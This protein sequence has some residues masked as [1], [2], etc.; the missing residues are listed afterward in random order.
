MALKQPRTWRLASVA[1][2]S[3]ILTSG[4]VFAEETAPTPS[5]EQRALTMDDAIQLALTN[6]VDILISK[7]TPRV[8]KFGLDALYSTYDPV[9]GM[10]VI[11]RYQNIPGQIDP[12]TGRLASFSE[13]NDEFTP[14]LT[15]ALPVGTTFTINGPQTHSQGPGISADGSY[16]GDV[17]ITVTQPLLKNFWI[18][19]PRWNIALA[20]GTLR[21]DQ[22]ALRQQ[23]MTVI[24]NVKSAYYNL[25]YDR[26]NV[27]V[28][29]EAVKLAD[30]LA[31]EDKQ[32]A[33]LGA[34]T[35]LDAA[36]AEAQAAASRSDLLTARLTLVSQEN[37]FKQMLAL[38]LR[39]WV[40]V[41]PVPSEQLVAIP[42]N[43]NLIESWQKA[44]ELRPD[45]QQAK[46]SL[47]KQ[48]ITIKYN[49][50]QLFP[51]LD[52]QG[53]YQHNGTGYTAGD[54]FRLIQSGAT[55]TYYYGASLTVPLDN[56]GARA[57]YKSAKATRDQL[58]LE[59]KKTENAAIVAIQN[60]VA[61][62]QSDF[63]KIDT[64]RAARA[65]AEQALQAE[66]TKLDHGKSTT[67]L[68]L[69][70]Q[71]TLT[72]D[73]S[74]EI[75]ALADYNIAVEQLAL[76]EGTILERNKIHWAYP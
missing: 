45:L 64:S 71:Q 63:L 50:N 21:Y 76:D 30:E 55:R 43:P 34:M 7:Q 15:G 1:L 56:I 35:P 31:T 14:T 49:Y 25:I 59:F 57:N 29:K 44:F 40:N 37:T 46:V 5:M 58:I 10:S 52:L 11:H 41:T 72:Q 6:D 3:L 18:D 73:R 19:T 51:E 23:V 13:Q 68:V 24:N 17:G 61:T 47:E 67:L 27:E 48:K 60:D 53:S 33:Q 4:A 70:A 38:N 36:S 32:K 69:Q 74:A 54:D 42:E 75:R 20:K 28:E 8:D 22:L 12:N 39:E 65:Y 9:F 66:Q 26:E 16:S 2:A 62:V